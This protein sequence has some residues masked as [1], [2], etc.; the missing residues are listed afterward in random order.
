[1]GIN[2]FGRGSNC[3]PELISPVYKPSTLQALKYG[4]DTVP[5]QFIFV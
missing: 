1:M 3:S 5:A 4:S 2:K